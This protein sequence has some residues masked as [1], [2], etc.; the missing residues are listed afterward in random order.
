MVF[1]SIAR[2]FDDSIGNFADSLC[3]F[4]GIRDVELNNENFGSAQRIER[5][6]LP[7]KLKQT[8]MLGGGDAKK[9][10]VEL[11]EKLRSEVRAF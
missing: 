1:I 6:Y 9:G 4:K 10:A 7:L 2:A 3:F 11:V 8:Q 5:V